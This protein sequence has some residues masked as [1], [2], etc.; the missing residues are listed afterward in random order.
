MAARLVGCTTIVGVDLNPQ[1]LELAR[2][3]GASHTIN[4]AEADPVE[5]IGQITGDGA[6]YSI[7]AIGLP[8]TLRQAVADLPIGTPSQPLRTKDGV[9]VLMV[10]AREG[11]TTADSEREAVRDQIYES[12]LL[13]LAEDF[14]RD[15]R[16][17][18]FVDIR[19]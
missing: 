3:L 8:D 7:E 4:A 19:L 18:A 5:A 14:L 17:Q 16:R 15:L 12:R 6:Q 13:T 11:D 1:R 10:C 9:I 2:E